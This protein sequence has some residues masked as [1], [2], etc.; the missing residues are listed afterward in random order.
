MTK[1]LKAKRAPQSNGTL[2]DTV[3]DHIRDEI[4]SGR[5]APGARLREVEIMQRLGVSRTPIREAVKA[6]EVEGLI[7][8]EPWQGIV[9]AKL[10]R[11]QASDLF[12]FRETLEGLAAGLAAKEITE[13]ELA[14]LEEL[15]RDAEECDINEIDTLSKKNRAFHQQIYNASRNRF[16]IQALNSLRISL[17]LLPGTAFTMRHRQKAIFEE[18]RT[19]FVALRDRNP[20]AATIA[21]RTHVKNSGMLLLS[22]FIGQDQSVD[23]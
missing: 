2:M 8:V 3:R 1:R 14:R 13:E 9:V 15:L 4:I 19:L 16:L 10:T 20:E 7:T 6:L 22:I 12:E 11:F 17:A 18:H 21:A 5:Y 23:A